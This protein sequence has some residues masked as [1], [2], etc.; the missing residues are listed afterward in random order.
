MDSLYSLFKKFSEKTFII[1]PANKNN[2]NIILTYKDIDNISSQISSYLTN[3]LN[4]NKGDRVV[5]CIGNKLEYI[6]FYYGL[7]KLRAVPIPF[8]INLTKDDLFYIQQES[9]PKKIIIRNDL[10]EKYDV[11]DFKDKIVECPTYD[12]ILNFNFTDA[13]NFVFQDMDD[14]DLCIILFTA[15]STG[16]PKG[17]QLKFNGWF[18]GAE[19]YG[20]LAMYNEDTRLLQIMPFYHADAWFSSLVV[21]PLFG[22]S[23]VLLE[24]FKIELISKFWNYVE[25]YNV[26]YLVVV[27]S[28]MTSL[29]LL[30]LRHN[31][32]FPKVDYVKC[33]SAVLLPDVRKNFEDVFKTKIIEVYGSTEG[34]AIT[35]FPPNEQYNSS[36][37]KLTGISEVRITTEGEIQIKNQKWFAGYLNRKDLTEQAFDNGWFRTGDVGEIRDGYLFLKGRKDDLIIKN[38]KN[39][40]PKEVDDVLIKFSND[41]LE[42]ATLGKFDK[43]GNQQ[44]FSFIVFKEGYIKNNI[45]TEIISFCRNHLAEYKIPDQIFFLE[46]IPKLASG[47]VDRNKLKDLII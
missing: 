24:S 18:E 28:I 42:S 7:L 17:V 34:H 5:L 33:S 25:N 39:I 40:S 31:K 43:D 8:D 47:K 29:L 3:Q 11:V 12:Q 45:K 19:K 13:N 35:I 16:K 2:N 20:K 37:G 30:A 41:I 10:I 26:N 15:G 38:G 14:E 22:S 1:I 44:I 21:A 9:S 32:P 6:F 27:P 36:V 23:T 4:I 46:A